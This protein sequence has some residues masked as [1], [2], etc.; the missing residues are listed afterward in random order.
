MEKTSG[1]QKH[2]EKTKAGMLAICAVCSVIAVTVSIFAFTRGLAHSDMAAKV[3]FA[4]EQHVKHQYFPDGFCYS[5]GVFILGIENLIYFFLTFIEDW[6]LC[7]QAAQFVQALLLFGSVFIFF[8]TIFGKEK[9]RIGFAA[10]VILLALPLS[11]VVYDLYYYQ[12]AYTKNV[13]FLLLL[14]AAAGKIMAE[15]NRRKKQ[16]WLLVFVLLT[17]CNNFGIRNIMLIEIPWILTVLIMS[18][19]FPSGRFQTGLCEKTIISL[20]CIATAAGLIFFKWVESYTGWDNQFE[21]VA[22]VKLETMVSQITNLMKAIFEIYGVGEHTALISLTGIALPFRFLYML[23]SV[24]IV[25]AAW[26]IFW[27]RIDH[28]IW[29]W[30]VGYCW[31]SN[32]FLT[33]FFLAT[34]TGISSFHMLS[35]Y[36]NNTILLAGAF[37]Y[38]WDHHIWKKAIG[39]ICVACILLFHSAYMVQCSETVIENE[40]LDKELIQYLDENDLDFGYAGFWNAY[41]YMLLTSGKIKVLAYTGEPNTSWYWLTCT[42][43]YDPGDHKGGTFRLRGKNERVADKYYQKAERADQVGDYTVL[44]FGQNL[45]DDPYLMYGILQEGYTQNIQT[46]DLYT[47]NKAWRNGDRIYLEEGGM[48]YGPYLELESGT[49][50]VR[51]EGAG[52]EQTVFELS[53]G[54]DHKR[55][56]V[57][58]IQQTQNQAVYRFSLDAFTTEAEFIAVNT[59]KNEAVIE[60]ISLTYLKKNQ[61][62]M[63]FYPYQLGHMGEASYYGGSILIEEG[64]MQYGPYVQ[65]EEGT[66]AVTVYGENLDLAEVKV[67]ADQGDTEIAASHIRKKEHLAQYQFRLAHAAKDV[68]CLVLNDQKEPVTVSRVCIQ[69]SNE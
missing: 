47:M 7:R 53:T 32:L 44:V 18:F 37:I 51:I 21:A 38:I 69:K 2:S 39:I 6:V 35:A 8:R 13:I 42:E 48:Q 23:V 1:T 40:A 26:L 29:K 33:Y 9:G 54:A 56:A 58:M 5:T 36:I 57:K 49:Y 3:L 4:H 19:D 17:V 55:E 10:G 34:S 11:D 22:F 24:V 62:S 16:I 65:L 12:A 25:P 28:Q 15:Q 68:E 45:T 64:G 14:F 41:K 59:G 31:L 43:W 66:Y 63:V 60:Q 52:L 27:K 20:S 46:K 50:E 67:T 30:F 61:E